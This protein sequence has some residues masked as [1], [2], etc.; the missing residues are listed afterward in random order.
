M[1]YRITLDLSFESL[2][3]ALDIWDKAMDHEDQAVNI[4]PGQDSEERGFL[5]LVECRHDEDPLAPCEELR[6]HEVQ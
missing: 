2:D 1:I 6:I 4:R 5:K 3:P